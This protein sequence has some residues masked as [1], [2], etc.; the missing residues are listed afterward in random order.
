MK[1]ILLLVALIFIL[2]RG[3]WYLR[4]NRIRNNIVRYSVFSILSS[5]LLAILHLNIYETF[6][7]DLT[8]DN[9][10]SLSA[11]FTAYMILFIFYPIIRNTIDKYSN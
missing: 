2:A 10:M 6:D 5:V 11:I 9:I 7:G 8:K 1:Y 3:N 4:N